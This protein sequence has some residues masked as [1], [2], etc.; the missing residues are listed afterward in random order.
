[1]KEEEDEQKKKEAA[2]P[3]E[4]EKA[5]EPKE[6]I[7]RDPAAQAEYEQTQRAMERMARRAQRAGGTHAAASGKD[8][9]AQAQQRRQLEEAQYKIQQLEERL[10]K[11]ATKKKKRKGS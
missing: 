1:M 8:I 2:A 9:L 7:V 6:E 10:T 4:K 11:S 3:K 5:P